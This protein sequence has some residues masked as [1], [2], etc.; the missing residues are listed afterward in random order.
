M[1][2]NHLL[3]FQEPVDTTRVNTWLYLSSA[4]KDL[5]M[6]QLKEVN[7]IAEAETI[8]YGVNNK[9]LCD[10]LELCKSFPNDM[11]EKIQHTQF[12]KDS[13]TRF[14]FDMCNVLCTLLSS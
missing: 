8:I 3:P 14:R 10:F 6:Q 4:Q 13:N 7:T 5:I 1:L 12:S 2:D 11:K 9:S